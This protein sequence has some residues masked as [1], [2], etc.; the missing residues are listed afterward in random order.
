[1]EILLLRDRTQKSL[2]CTIGQVFINDQFECYSLE[3]V[4]REVDGQPP[5]KWKVK[6]KTAITRGRYEVLMTYSNR[7]GRVMPQIMN[8]PGFDGIRI[9][10]GNTDED[11]EGCILLGLQKADNG[12]SI[13]D[14]QK[15]LK[16]FTAKLEY[17][18]SQSERVYITVA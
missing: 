9:H 5:V 4:I 10:A 17:A 14:S 7:F 1:M 16:A 8:V 2:T 3:D 15:A 18:F 13:M 11:T 12:E 6:G